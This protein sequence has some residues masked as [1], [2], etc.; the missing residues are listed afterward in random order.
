M[1][2]SG[3]DQLNV[4]PS[5]VMTAAQYSIAQAAV[6]VT[7]S[8]LEMIQNSGKERMI[9]LLETRIGNAERTMKNNLSSD[10]YSNGRSLH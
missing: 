4:S 3:Y 10:C 6:A 9:P 5:D 7:I 2:Y 1:R 8:G